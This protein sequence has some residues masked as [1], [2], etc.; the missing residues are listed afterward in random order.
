[1]KKS[2]RFLDL[3][4]TRYVMTIYLEENFESKIT[5]QLSYSRIIISTLI[6]FVLFTGLGLIASRTLLNQILDPSTK[7]ERL[8]KEL[9]RLHNKTDS[10]EHLVQVN[11][12]YISMLQAAFNP[13]KEVE[14]APTL[15]SKTDSSEVVRI[16]SVD[17]VNP[18]E[19]AFRR[20]YEEQTLK[21]VINKGQEEETF[22]SNRHLF[23]P[24]VNNLDLTISK[25]GSFS[26]QHYGI[27]IN[28]RKQEKILAI[29]DGTVIFA[30]WTASDGFIIGIQH[31]DNYVSVYKH[32]DQLLKKQGDRVTTA[33]PIAMMGNTG[34]NSSG[35]HLHFEIWYKGIPV[36]PTTLIYF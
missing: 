9:A 11:D 12:D 3:L 33:E 10:L 8:E 35:P 29:A 20:K 28:G 5:V 13:E 6:L 34:S 23:F 16:T 15:A 30:Y 7:Q 26:S 24:P 36:D 19:L 2:T 27:D 17:D 1:M 21:D 31:D 18:E 32:N 4:T 22:N 14:A 25:Q